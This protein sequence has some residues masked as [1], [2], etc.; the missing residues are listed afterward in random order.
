MLA[1]RLLVVEHGQ[2]ARRPHSE[3][4]GSTRANPP[5]LKRGEPEPLK[6]Q[7]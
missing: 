7:G 6:P 2:K 4:L 1:Q 5:Q 3:R